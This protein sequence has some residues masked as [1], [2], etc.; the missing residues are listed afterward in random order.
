VTAEDCEDLAC[1]AS[2]LVARARAILPRFD[3]ITLADRPEKPP[4]RQ[5]GVPAPG[6]VLLLVATSGLELPPTPSVGLLQEIDAYVRARLPPAA[7]LRIVG[8]SWVE[9]R[10]AKITV[11]TAS[12]EATEALRR[13]VERALDAFLHPITGGDGARGWGFGQIPRESDIHR[14]VRSIPGVDHVGALEL[15]MIP[16]PVPG[17]STVLI[18]PGPH[19]IHV[20]ALGAA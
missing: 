10:V 16:E 8:P 19:T 9:V 7:D 14:L 20:T 6:G 2:P 15:I 17:D 18:Y 12:A 5:P 1:E 11:V 4:E 13:R 3:V